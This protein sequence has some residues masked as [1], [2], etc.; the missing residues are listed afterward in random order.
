MARWA[1]VDNCMQCPHRKFGVCD[2]VVDTYTLL[3]V[4]K[5]LNRVIQDILHIPGWCPLT[6]VQGEKAK[7]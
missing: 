3:D 7:P 4:A 6:Q 5:T 2:L 1:R